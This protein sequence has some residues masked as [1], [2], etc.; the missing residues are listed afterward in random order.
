MPPRTPEQQALISQAMSL[1]GQSRSKRKIAA[2][3]ENI[4]LARAAGK[5]MGGWPKGKSRGKKKSA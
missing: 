5:K 2:V 3:T 1:L 4:R